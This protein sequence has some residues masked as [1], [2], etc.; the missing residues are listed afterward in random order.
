MNSFIADLGLAG[1]KPILTALLLPPMPFLLLG[2]WSALLVWSRRGI[3][4][5][6]MFIT[7]LGIY[8]STCAGTGEALSAMLLKP[9]RAMQPSQIETLK[10]SN[11]GRK[12]AVVVVLGGGRESFAPE[13]GV[14]SL[15]DSSLARLRYGLWLG[16][17]TG[18]P[19]AFSGGSGWGQ[20][21]GLSEA[22]IASRIAAS[23]FG[24]PLRWS[25]EQ[26]RDT[27]EN[28]MRTTA[29]LANSDVG[30]IILV[31]HGWHMPRA[32]REFERAGAG[33]Y[34]ITAAPM[35]MAPRIDR[36]VLVWLPSGEGFTLVRQVLREA[37]GLLVSGT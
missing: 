21:D 27:R 22:Q 30:E 7:A 17:E 26:S 10:A 6:L 33:R 20:S 19:V 18:L 13:Y 31:T 11:A 2:F 35:A 36:Q 32:M 5:A 8:L 16:R 37:V 14:A 25:E 29:M 12:K 24:R 4:W 9:P 3:G 23:E 1:W 15:S 34:K 28:A